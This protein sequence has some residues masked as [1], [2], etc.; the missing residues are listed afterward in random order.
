MIR[1]IKRLAC[2][3]SDTNRYDS[4]ASLA[5]LIIHAVGDLITPPDVVYRFWQVSPLE[6][7]VFL[8]TVIIMVFTDLETGIY[9]AICFS[10]AVVL[11]RIAKT[12]GRFL[13]RARIYR[14]GGGDS[15]RGGRP[16]SVSGSSGNGSGIGKEGDGEKTA[17]ITSRETYLPLHHRDGTN[18]HIQ[19]EIPYPGVLVY[20]FSEGFNYIN[21]G[22]NMDI[23]TATVKEETRPTVLDKY[24]KL[25]VSIPIIL[26]F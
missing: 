18:P 7:L 3:V 22:F 8:A 11:V 24:T 5:G 12:R 26:C 4:Q 25:G 14:V 23:L 9:F 1:N 19:I 15:K 10:V 2:K 6:A 20:R 16:G 13:G 17:L 21:A